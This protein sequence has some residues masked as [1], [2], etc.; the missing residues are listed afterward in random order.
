MELASVGGLP[1]TLSDTQVKKVMNASEKVIR[2]DMVFHAERVEPLLATRCL[3]TH[4]DLAL[5]Q[6]MP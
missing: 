2:E 4:H 3:T 1:V 5:S 6:T